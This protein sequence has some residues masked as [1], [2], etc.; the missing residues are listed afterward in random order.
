LA[1]SLTLVAAFFG[2]SITFLIGYFIIRR[3]KHGKERLMECYVL[4]AGGVIAM[5]FLSLCLGILSGFALGA[6]I[7][8]NVYYSPFMA[9]MLIDVYSQYRKI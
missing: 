9:I 2:F 5:Q 1:V 4:M 6:I 7:L 3:K 8:V